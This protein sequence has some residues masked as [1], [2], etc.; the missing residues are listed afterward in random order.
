MPAT[1]GYGSKTFIQG[2][3]R[4]AC[5]LEAYLVKHDSTLRT[6]LPGGAGGAA[7]ACITSIEP[8]LL[9]LCALKNK[10]AR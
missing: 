4:F 1:Y 2:M 6:Y 9:T 8:C 3:A 5:K 7:Y 10:S